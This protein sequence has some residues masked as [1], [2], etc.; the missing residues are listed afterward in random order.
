MDL[1]RI[2][3]ILRAGLLSAVFKHKWSPVIGGTLIRYRYSLRAFQ[4]F[5][6]VTKILGWDEKWFYFEQKLETPSGAAAVALAKGLI[7]SKSQTV[8]PAEVLAIIGISQPP[9]PFDEAVARWLAAEEML[10]QEDAREGLGSMKNS[11]VAG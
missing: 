7:L 9:P 11:E 6:I 3:F 8:S 5:E 1:G 4:K 10:H 2:D